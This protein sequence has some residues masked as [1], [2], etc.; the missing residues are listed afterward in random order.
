MS[1]EAAT[2]PTA[3]QFTLMPLGRAGM[4]CEGDSCEIPSVVE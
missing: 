3:P 1:D 4:I 2:A